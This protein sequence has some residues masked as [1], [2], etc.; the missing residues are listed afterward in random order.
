MSSSKIFVSYAR[1]DDAVARQI[2]EGLRASNIALWRDQDDIL[3]GQRWDHAIE[4]AIEECSD[5]IVL[6]S[7]NSAVSEVVLDEINYALERK[8]RVLPVVIESCKVPLR[9]KRL[10]SVRFDSDYDASMQRLLRAITENRSPR[11][12]DEAEPSFAYHP[13]QRH[14]PS[15]AVLPFETL[16]S[17]TSAEVL[18][19]GLLTEIVE[20]L[21][22]NSELFVIASATTRGY[23]DRARNVDQIAKQLRVSYLLFGQLTVLDTRL[24]VAC[25][26]VSAGSGRAVWTEHFDRDIADVFAVQDAIAR[27]I[28]HRLQRGLG[29]HER[30][31]IVRKAPESLTAW[32]IFQQARYYEWSYEWLTKSITLL[33]R[34]I[35]LDPELAEAHALLAARMAY[36]IWYGHLDSVAQSLAHAARALELAP[37]NAN[38]LVC[39]SVAQNYNGN[40]Q[41]ALNLVER[42]LEI[43]PNSA[44][45]WGY[46]GLYL[47][48]IGRNKEALDML[49]Y[50]FE[51]SPKDPV[52]YLWYAH[53]AICYVNQDDYETALELFTQ[54]T[55][56]HDQWFWSFM[57]QAQ[58]H[59]VLGHAEEARRDWAHAK[60]LN[61][62][63]SVATFKIWLTTSP[64][65]R[66]QQRAV[67][68]AVEKAGC[69]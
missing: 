57:A 64:L 8:K 15:I 25:E 55:R 59:A 68:S 5:L 32:E 24:R 65:T 35:E 26:L 18:S 58:S 1:A 50:A 39:S 7:S 33:K 61:P 36:M 56:L 16:S 52:R 40:P 4:Q 21:S 34:A 27:A 51:L 11:A 45:A 42:A 48:V 19:D 44:D 69:E 31:K 29:A 53:K 49:D 6:L 66:E 12:S 38:C 37:D 20:A 67:V 41:K 62:I 2:A 54:S 17:S 23:R 60:R 3:P 43:N 46:N 28:A 10:E 30:S 47:A 9:L 22:R 63:V 14:K 13:G